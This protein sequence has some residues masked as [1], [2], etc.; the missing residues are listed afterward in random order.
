LSGSVDS[1][2]TERVLEILGL[3]PVSEGVLKVTGLAVTEAS[4]IAGLESEVGGTETDNAG[5]ERL[6]DA[7][8][9]DPRDDVVEAAVASAT[10]ETAAA[11][12]LSVMTVGLDTDEELSELGTDADDVAAAAGEAVAVVEAVAAAAEVVAGRWVEFLATTALYCC[13]SITAASSN[14]WMFRRQ[15]IRASTAVRS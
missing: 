6:V 12:V 8:M 9:E 10:D 2:S 5:V 1:F 13:I 15:R 14:T 11:V 3:A 7:E 4:D